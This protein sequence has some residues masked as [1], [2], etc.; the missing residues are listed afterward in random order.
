[1][2]ALIILNPQHV[3]MRRAISL[4]QVAYPASCP[5]ILPDDYWWARLLD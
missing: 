3:F 4:R 5:D 1:M 2:D